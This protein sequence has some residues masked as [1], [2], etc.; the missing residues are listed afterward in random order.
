MKIL[1][2]FAAIMM[3]LLPSIVFAS[4]ENTIC[5]FDE[6]GFLILDGRKQFPIGIFVSFSPAWID[7]DPN[8][9]E[10]SLKDIQTSPF[11]FMINYS[12]RSGTLDQKKRYYNQVS[13][14]N[15]WEFFGV[16]KYFKEIGHDGWQIQ[17]EGTE[18]EVIT[19]T[20][21]ELKELPG[22][23]GWYIWDELPQDANLV[24]DH[25]VWAKAAD[26]SRPTL[27][28]SSQHETYEL[29][30]YADSGDIFGID[31]Y[32][33]P[34]RGDITLVADVMDNL[35][36]ATP[37]NKPLWLTVQGFGDYVYGDARNGVKVGPSTLRGHLRGPTPAEMRCMT[38][39]SLVHGAKG[40]I[41]Y[42]YKD[43]QVSYDKNTRWPAVKAIASDVKQIEPILLAE[44]FSSKL[45]HANNIN[46][47]WMAKYLNGKIYIVAVN[48]S[49]EVQ[50]ILFKF[51][52]PVHVSNIMQGHSFNYANDK[53]MVL[54]M[55]GYNS[56]VLELT[57]VSD[58]Q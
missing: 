11:N 7:S 38:Y 42:Y 16:E 47:H 46:I 2:V 44:K 43:F 24:R 32:P 13:K 5:K 14:H 29:K 28:L 12:S 40:I 41:F 21:S 39:L 30:Q 25:H 45:V 15:L 8:T 22:I 51:S 56:I 9:L 37:S 33:L 31:R 20:I 48:A 1:S 6:K 4:S 49:R 50:N 10:E 23:L 58:N 55:D 53:E 17:F 18:Q 3:L 52:K 19:K 35:T 34:S 27:I 54:I 57:E 36:S 26:S